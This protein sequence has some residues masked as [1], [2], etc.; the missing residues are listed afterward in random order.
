MGSQLC[1]LRDTSKVPMIKAAIICGDPEKNGTW[2]RQT[3]EKP[4][5]NE[6]GESGSIL[7]FLSTR[8]AAVS[9]VLCLNVS[10]PN[11]CSS[12]CLYQVRG[13][14]VSVGVTVRLRERKVC[15]VY[16]AFFSMLTWKSDPSP[17]SQKVWAWSTGSFYFLASLTNC[18]EWEEL[19]S[20]GNLR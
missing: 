19:V 9:L 18:R 10:W 13:S 14:W 20:S 17:P 8:R 7:S 3:P 5:A 11:N 4:V 15:A 6:G 2:P 12:S 1:T 16:P